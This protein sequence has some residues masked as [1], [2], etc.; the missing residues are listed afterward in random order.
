MGFMHE[1]EDAAFAASFSM[2]GNERYFIK[3]YAQMS[4][5]VPG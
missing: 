4:E 1:R 3:H 2:K 5:R